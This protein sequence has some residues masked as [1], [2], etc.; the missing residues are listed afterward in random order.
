MSA[1][2]GRVSKG[3]AATLLADVY[4]TMKRIP[5]LQ[6][7][8][9]ATSAGHSTCQLQE[10]RLSASLHTNRKAVFSFLNGKG[11]NGTILNF[12]TAPY[13]WQDDQASFETATSGKDLP[14]YTYPDVL[15]MAAEA[16]ALSEGV[17]A[18]A[19]DYLSQ[20]RARAYWKTDPA[21]SP[22]SN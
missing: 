15:L 9:Y 8:D 6:Q 2:A 12:P 21:I 19:V 14:I 3:T 22:A 10:W 17:T 5:V 16:I 1:N 18:E 4:L 13:M 20:V 7:N 11:A